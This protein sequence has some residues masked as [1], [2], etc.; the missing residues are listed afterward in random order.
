MSLEA[1]TVYHVQCDNEGC[2]EGTPDF[3]TIY[4][5]KQ[6]ME[7]EGWSGDTFTSY[8][9]DCTE[10]GARKAPEVDSMEFEVVSEQKADFKPGV[11]DDAEETP[12]IEEKPEPETKKSKKG[13][14]DGNAS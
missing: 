4:E 1:H 11:Q 2:Q 3:E 14:K 8:C 6:Y 5:A 13:G 7:G 10:E 12:E 9:P